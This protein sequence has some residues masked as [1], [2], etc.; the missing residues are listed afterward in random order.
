MS[1]VLGNVKRR[2]TRRDLLIVIGRLQGAIGRAQAENNDRNP[3]RFAQVN[4]VLGAA[5]DLCVDVR[6]YDPPILK[7]TGPWADDGKRKEYV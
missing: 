4:G 1:V 2:P 5:L 7:D 3:N 6:G